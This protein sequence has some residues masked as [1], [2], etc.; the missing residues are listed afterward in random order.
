MY[1]KMLLR[2]TNNQE[3]WNQNGNEISPYTIRMTII[4]KNDK[5]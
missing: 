5:C 2:I 1:M 4:K 3:N